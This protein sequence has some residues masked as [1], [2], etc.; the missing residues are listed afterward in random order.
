MMKKLLLLLIAV[1]MTAYN[2]SSQDIKGCTHKIQTE[3][4][5]T[6]VGQ[7]KEYS[8]VIKE[9]PFLDSKTGDSKEWELTDSFYIESY[10]QAGKHL[11]V[12]F[13]KDNHNF[14]V[15]SNH[16][17]LTADAVNALEK[18]PK[19]MRPDLQNVFSQLSVSNQN[20]WAAIINNAVDPYVDEIAFSIAHSSTTYL[21]SVYSYTQLFEE[22]AE[23]IYSHD[24]DLAYVEVIDYGTSAT[25]ENYY[26]TTRYRT[27]NESKDTVWVEA[28]M[29]IYYWYVVLPKITDEIPAYINPTTIEN[30]HTDN[31]TDPPTG[32][33]WRDYLYSYADGGYPV[34]KDSLMDCPVLWDDSIGASTTNNAVAAITNWAKESMDFTSDAER[35]HQPVRIYKKHIGRCGEWAD[36]TSAAARAAL[37][38]STSILSTS[39]DHTWN[40][41][42][43][44]GWFHWEPV[45]TMIN[46]PLHYEKG[47][48]WN[49]A[50]VFEI[51]SDGCLFPVTQTY[52]AG[53]STINIYALDN[54]ND[55]IDGAKIL[56]AVLN[57]EGT[58]IYVDNFGY[59]D[60]EGKYTF[61]VGES[62]HYYARLD[63]D[64]G[65]DPA[66]PNNVYSL[67]DSAVNGQ[68]YN[69]SLSPDGVMPAVNISSITPPEDIVDDYLM[70]VEF[71]AL[72][73]IIT[74]KI[75][76]DDLDNS[77]F[78]DKQDNGLTNF[79]IIN[80]DNYSL[81]IG[82]NAFD[83]FHDFE[84]T[85]SGSA[86][87]DIPA[88]EHWYALLD[89]GN[90][91]NN[92]QFIESSILLYRDSSVG[93][94]DSDPGSFALMQ[95]Y[96]NP[97]KLSTTIEYTVAKPCNV[98]I[99]IYD[100]FGREVY[101][102]V[103]E[104]KPSGKFSVIWNGKDTKGNKLAVGVYYYKL[105]A[106]KQVDTKKM[107]YLR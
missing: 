43:D 30:T 47:W 51:R 53:S 5:F 4:S 19:W 15:I 16:G 105:T 65:G 90:S 77:Y 66:T 34:L 101:V 13:D 37:I 17:E 31:I 36:L 100:L 85:F 32:K 72:Q 106:G 73:Q 58:S 39:G 21:S 82:D 96:P 80:P 35:P 76:M 97:F 41:F 23:L 92:P 45:N 20:K 67:I 48:G 6:V 12:K 22:N 99:K 25:D 61:I 11:G 54:N 78:F 89:N 26:S 102:S 86:S 59:T 71:T 1:I 24:I 81:Y 44:E 9:K 14:E 18:S 103:N 49:F 62:R 94:E 68:T 8:P 87:F 91:L 74:G 46:V 69:Y 55:P 83:G 29:E 33:F 40:E 38:P 28:P 107:L 42:W 70:E 95:N 52:S 75:I 60:N 2:L 27:M 57:D 93:I 79:F 104:Q 84:D 98:Q 56:L 63:S 88:E 3:K 10:I 7:A 64:I 50:S